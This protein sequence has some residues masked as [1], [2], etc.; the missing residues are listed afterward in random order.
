MALLADNLKRL[1]VAPGAWAVP[2][3]SG[4]ACPGAREAFEPLLAVARAAAGDRSRA[5]AWGLW[6]LLLSFGLG[7]AAFGGAP[8][9]SAPDFEVKAEYLFVFTK[10][11]EWPAGT[12]VAAGEPIVIGVIGDEAIGEALE[13]YAKGRTTQGGRKVT[14]LRARRS[15][16]LVGCQVVFVGQGERRNLREITEVLGNK[17]ALTVCDTDGLFTQGLMIKFV[18]INENVRFEV[19]LE[20]V[21]RAGLSIQ[22]G[23]LASANRVWRK[24]SSS[25]EP[26]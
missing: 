13:R 14:V 26:P 23:M 20:P 5:G 10:Y 24:A 21:E 12:L 11:V 1:R 2:A 25:L 15:A 3:R 19:K 4:S 7:L 6:S 17:P 22:S 8:A 18:L 16:D 9:R